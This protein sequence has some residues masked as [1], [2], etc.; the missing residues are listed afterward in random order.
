MIASTTSNSIDVNAHEFLVLPFF[1]S[2]NPTATPIAGDATTSITL[3]F[4]RLSIKPQNL[5]KVLII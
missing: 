4:I 5:C 3:Q 1:S 2:R